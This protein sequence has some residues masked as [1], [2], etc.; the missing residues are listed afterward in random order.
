MRFLF[1]FLPIQL[2]AQFDLCP[3]TPWADDGPQWH[4]YIEHSGFGSGWNAAGLR[5]H[6]QNFRGHVCVSARGQCS[7]G[8]LGRIAITPMTQLLVGWGLEQKKPIF[9]GQWTTTYNDYQEIQLH[10]RLSRSYTGY[11]VTYSELL[12]SGW[13]LGATALFA[14]NTGIQYV[15]QVRPP[16]IQN[17]GRLYV[18][19]SGDWRVEWRIPHV[20]ISFGSSHWP[21][22]RSSLLWGKEIA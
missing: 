16:G 11:S 18:S 13:H 10:V 5:W 4:G 22:L 15:I 12:E 19:T 6:S 2:M 17:R 8:G 7:L 21:W 9:Y 14:P 1:L 20:R 3:W